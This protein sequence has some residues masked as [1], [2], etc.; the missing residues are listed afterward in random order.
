MTAPSQPL[1]QKIINLAKKELFKKDIVKTSS[2]LL[3][4]LS[5][6]QVSLS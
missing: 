4:R 3:E 2:K 6:K 5:K 1:T